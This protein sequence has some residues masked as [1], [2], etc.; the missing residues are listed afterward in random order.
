MLP[1]G[2]LRTA[3]HGRSSGQRLMR[4]RGGEERNRLAALH[5]KAWAIL[6]Q[7]DTPNENILAGS[8]ILLRISA[9]WVRLLGLYSPRRQLPSTG[10]PEAE[11]EEPAKAAILLILREATTA[12]LYEIRAIY[13][14]VQASVTYL[15]PRSATTSPIPFA[16][17]STIRRLSQ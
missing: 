2:R 16:T 14:R 6:H 17:A 10:D 9:R 13:E 3:R 11:T 8:E 12:E 4:K 5:L 7:P 1:G 15:L